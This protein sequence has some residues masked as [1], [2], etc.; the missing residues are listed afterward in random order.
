MYYKLSFYKRVTINWFTGL[1]IRQLHVGQGSV[2]IKIHTDINIPD[3]FST[4]LQIRYE[5]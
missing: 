4:E 5:N 1:I 2:L 3:T